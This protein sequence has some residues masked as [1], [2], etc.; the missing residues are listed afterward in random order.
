LQDSIGIRVWS[1]ASEELFVSTIPLTVPDALPH[2][3]QFAS[4]VDPRRTRSEYR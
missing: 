4:D 3:S 2:T 1:S